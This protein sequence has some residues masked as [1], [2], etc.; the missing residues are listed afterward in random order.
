MLVVLSTVGDGGSGAGGVGVD[1][2]VGGHRCCLP[3][4]PMFLVGV[5][6]K[7]LLT[8]VM[9]GDCAILVNRK[10]ATTYAVQGTYSQIW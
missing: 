9:N 3:S 1:V 4:P 6:L 2:D 10:E 8:V 5:V 7:T